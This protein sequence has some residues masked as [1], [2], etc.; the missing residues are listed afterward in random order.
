MLVTNP[1][2]F[3]LVEYFRILDNLSKKFCIHENGPV[4]RIEF[5]LIAQ[6]I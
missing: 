3:R 1:L 5:L 2:V 4:N 6:T